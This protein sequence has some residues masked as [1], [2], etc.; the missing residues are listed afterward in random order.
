VCLF[1][2]IESRLSDLIVDCQRLD[3]EN[4]RS[5]VQT[6]MFRNRRMT[7]Q[8]PAPR[9]LCHNRVAQGSFNLRGYRTMIDGV[10][11]SVIEDDTA[12]SA[13]L[14]NLEGFSIDQL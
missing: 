1:N 11:M 12:E 10:A 7:G 13:R 9:V 3:L 5:Y 2:K 8:G 6:A 4:G 14:M